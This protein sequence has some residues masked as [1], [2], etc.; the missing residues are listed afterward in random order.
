MYTLQPLWTQAREKL[1]VVTII[2]ANRSYGVLNQELQRVGAAAAGP[3]ALSMLDLHD[4]SLDWLKL[5][6]GMGVQAVRTDSSQ[7]LADAF[8]SA[9]AGSGPRLIEALL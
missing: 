2:Y 5:A 7:G 3:K 1:D 4:P 8:T 9:I 6:E